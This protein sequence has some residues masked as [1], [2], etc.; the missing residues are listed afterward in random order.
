MFTIINVLLST[1]NIV[2][3]LEQTGEI[4]A[5]PR[6]YSVLTAG[7]CSGSEFTKHINLRNKQFLGNRYESTAAASESTDAPTEK[8]EYQAEVHYWNYISY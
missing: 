6:W 2:L 8:Y 1:C 5:Q 4:D 3:N 7:R